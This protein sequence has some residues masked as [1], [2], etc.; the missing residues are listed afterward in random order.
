MRYAQYLANQHGTTGRWVSLFDYGNHRELEGFG[1]NQC[2]ATL[3]GIT[4]DGTSPPLTGSTAGYSLWYDNDTDA[5]QREEFEYENST[6]Q[7]FS[8]SMTET[9]SIGIEISATEGVP[10]VAS[11]TQKFT[12]NFSLSST[13]T[14]S[15]SE[16]K[17]WTVKTPVV[18]PARKSVKCTMVINTEGYDLDF[19][20]DVLVDGDVAVYFEDPVNLSIPGAS[21]F[22]R[23][24]IPLALLL[25]EVDHLRLAN[26]DGY[27]PGQYTWGSQIWA[28][29]K[30]KFT[31]NQGVSVGVRAEQFP[32]RSSKTA[33]VRAVPEKSM[34][35]GLK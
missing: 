20:A 28:S 27:R 14:T 17:V 5:E 6:E 33:A 11:S 21:S 34:I 10:E 25:W 19:T 22:N 24:F 4:Y 9:L 3:K 32:V 16:K 1:A 7:T 30:G 2:K 12:I 23:N 35:L 8:W 29:P 13:Q 31:G 18:V 26:T 15:H